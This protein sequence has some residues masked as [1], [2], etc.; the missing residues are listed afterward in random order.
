ME[1]LIVKVRVIDVEGSD[2]VNAPGDFSGIDASGSDVWLESYGMLSVELENA[3]GVEVSFT[4]S[5]SA[6]VEMLLPE[7]ANFHVTGNRLKLQGMRWSAEGAAEMAM[8]RS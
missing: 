4:K 3:D 6:E 7:S 5:G 8:L 1:T 2:I